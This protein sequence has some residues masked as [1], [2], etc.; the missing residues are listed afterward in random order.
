MA[1][2]MVL[3]IAFVSLGI[4]IICT[5]YDQETETGSIADIRFGTAAGSTFI[6]FISMLSLFFLY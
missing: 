4:S 5:K 6:L 2:I 3:L 1:K